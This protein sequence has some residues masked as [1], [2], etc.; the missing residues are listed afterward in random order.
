M[1][2]LAS[3]CT[4]GEP[5]VMTSKRRHGQSVDVTALSLLS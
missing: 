4:E 3:G 1:A 2:V 5:F